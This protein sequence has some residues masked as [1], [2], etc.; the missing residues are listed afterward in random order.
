MHLKKN[1]S[2]KNTCHI[3]AKLNYKYMKIKHQLELLYFQ[4]LM[5]MDI[6]LTFYI[7]IIIYQS[8]NVKIFWKI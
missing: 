7:L 4:G 1:A 6:V 8:F 3:F 2:T 5:C